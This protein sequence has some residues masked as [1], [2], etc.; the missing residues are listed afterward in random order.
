MLQ[1]PPSLALAA[2]SSSSNSSS[3]R[4]SGPRVWPLKKSHSAAQQAQ[5]RLAPL[6]LPPP[7]PP[8]S[9][10][11][12]TCRLGQAAA[13]TGAIQVAVPQAAVLRPRPCAWPHVLVPVY[14]SS[15]HSNT[16]CTPPPCRAVQQ[17]RAAARGALAR[18]P[19]CSEKRAAESREEGHGGPGR[20]HRAAG[21]HRR[22]RACCVRCIPATRLLHGVHR[23]RGLPHARG[24]CARTLCAAVHA[25]QMLKDDPGELLRRL[26]VIFVE[27]AIAHP[28]AVPVV[29]WLMAAQVRGR[30]SAVGP[31]QHTHVQLRHTQAT[32]VQLHHP[33][34]MWGAA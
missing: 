5:A 12:P 2:S 7:S 9:R 13:W 10:C 17:H 6:P 11:T 30:R 28:H 4:R 25:T 15:L 19:L 23:W 1:G 26:P 34:R 20:A 21:A 24:T 31:L 8:P 27:D 18:P 14:P 32:R 3:P 16:G 29:V 22:P 33:A